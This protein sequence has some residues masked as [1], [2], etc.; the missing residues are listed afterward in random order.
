ML[1]LVFYSYSSLTSQKVEVIFSRILLN[2]VSSLIGLEYINFGKSFPV[3]R[4]I[5]Y[6]SIDQRNSSI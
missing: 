3:F 6:R 2:K 1:N 4:N 5:V